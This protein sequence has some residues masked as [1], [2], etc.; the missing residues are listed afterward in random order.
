[1]PKDDRYSVSLKEYLAEIDVCMGGKVAEELIYGA[2]NVTTGASSDISN[3]TRLAYMM[4]T[5]AGMSETLG[6]IDLS[7]DYARLSSETKQ[8]IEHEVR[9]LVEEGRERAWK[10]LTTNRAGL[11]RLA[12]ALV[13]YE[14]LS[15]EEM[16]KVVRGEK[17]TDKITLTDML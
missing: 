11:D 8:Q 16:E 10:L 5:Q 15:K 3:A 1:M 13:E 12:M 9:R 7:S 6:N 14:T 17:L 4:V 2:D